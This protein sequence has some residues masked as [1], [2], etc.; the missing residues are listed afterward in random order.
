MLA[1]VWAALAAR[2]VDRV[3]CDRAA[4]DRDRA[5]RTSLLARPIRPAI[6][7]TL[8]ALGAPDS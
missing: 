6:L 1:F 5:A 8:P 7:A 3:D 2:P 4:M